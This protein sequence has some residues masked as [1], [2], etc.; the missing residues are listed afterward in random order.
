MIAP[1][2]AII[3]VKWGDEIN[4]EVATIISKPN[5]VPRASSGAALLS[6][7]SVIGSAFPMPPQDWHIKPV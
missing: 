2:K 6:M 3:C 1:A 7:R 5:T 4:A